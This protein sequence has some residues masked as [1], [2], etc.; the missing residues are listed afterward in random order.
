MAKINE[1]YRMYDAKYKNFYK[2]INKF[3]IKKKGSDKDFIWDD[4]CYIPIA[5]TIALLSKGSSDIFAIKNIIVDASTVASL[6]G[7]KYNNK[8]IIKVDSSIKDAEYHEL[9]VNANNIFNII[10]YGSYLEVNLEDFGLFE[11]DGILC[12]IEYDINLKRLELRAN[13]VLKDKSIKPLFLHL[14]ENKTLLECI[15][16]TL[17][18]TSDEIKKEIKN[19]KV[20]NISLLHTLKN[21]KGQNE[22]Y[23]LNYIIFSTLL[24][25]LEK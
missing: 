21:L 1:I 15:E 19:N 12:N 8:K 16:D 14:L 23:L 11:T 24:F 5:G 9:D 25:I 7:W 17:N 6:C 20:N 10:G 4:K 13:V 3:F 22:I 2:D 18:F